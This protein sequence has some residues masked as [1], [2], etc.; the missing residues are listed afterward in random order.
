MVAVPGYEYTALSGNREG[1]NDKGKRE[2][3]CGRWFKYVHTL[4]TPAVYP[5]ATVCMCV[6]ILYKHSQVDQECSV[7]NNLSTLR[8][9]VDS[10]LRTLGSYVYS[11]TMYLEKWY[12]K[13][14][15][16]IQSGTHSVLTGFKVISKVCSLDPKWYPQ[17]AHW[18]QSGT[19][20]VL[21]GFKVV[22]KV[23]SMDPKW[24]PKWYP[25]CA[26]WIQKYL[27]PVPR[28]SVDALL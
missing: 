1:S 7:F 4:R 9:Q 12:P 11:A 22:P 28:G 14:A 21:I 8:Q 26:H 2:F 6:R 3:Y 27:Q 5:P 23:C 20:N 17:C 10:K 15:H 16:W 19:Q 24:Y 25:K 13:C 18:I